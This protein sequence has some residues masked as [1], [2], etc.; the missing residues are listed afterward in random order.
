LQKTNI[1]LDREFKYF[2]D[3]QS[4]KKDNYVLSKLFSINYKLNTNNIHE[5]PAIFS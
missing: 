2:I 4:G 1:M 5:N 3:N